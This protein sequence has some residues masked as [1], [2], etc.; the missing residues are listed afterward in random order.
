MWSLFASLF[1]LGCLVLYR[2]GVETRITDADCREL[3][4]RCHQLFTASMT[5]SVN[6]VVCCV[7]GSGE[8]F[9]GGGGGGDSGRGGCGSVRVRGNDVVVV[10]GVIVVAVVVVVA[11]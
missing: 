11:V 3:D 6:R 7:G 5:T 9:S 1:T 10:V 8:W 2:K 4:L